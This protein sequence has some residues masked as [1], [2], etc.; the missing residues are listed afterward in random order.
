MDRPELKIIVLNETIA[1]LLEFAYL[2]NKS[3]VKDFN[4]ECEN[5][6]NADSKFLQRDL[7]TIDNDMQ[8]KTVITYYFMRSNSMNIY[9]LP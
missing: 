2:R 1:D 8:V 9:L 7:R 4:E 3:I 5:A 6:L